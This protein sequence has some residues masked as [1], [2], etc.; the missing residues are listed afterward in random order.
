MAA[1]VSTRRYARSD[2]PIGADVD[3]L[4]RLMSKPAD[5]R[6]FVSHTGEHFVELMLRR[7]HSVIC[8][9]RC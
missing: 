6:E 2:D 7:A 8:T 9:S 5:S 4:A 3:A 1:G